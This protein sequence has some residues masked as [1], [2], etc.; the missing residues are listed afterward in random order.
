[1][2]VA[3][4]VKEGWWGKE[5][6]ERLGSG[7]EDLVRGR[8]REWGAIKVSFFSMGG[9]VVV[10]LIEGRI[11]RS[12]QRR[13]REERGLIIRRVSFSFAGIQG[14]MDFISEW[15]G[16]TQTYTFQGFHEFRTGTI[17]LLG[18]SNS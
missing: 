16:Q 12:G 17:Y 4:T 13:G 3:L 9:I 10:S 2:E 11:G 18:S 15:S 6:N 5:N 14:T 8:E 7:V 1:M